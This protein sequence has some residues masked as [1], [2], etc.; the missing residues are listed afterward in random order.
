MG[1]SLKILLSC[2]SYSELTGSE[3]Y[4]YELAKTLKKLGHGV[5]VISSRVGGLLTEKSEKIG[6]K[7]YDFSRPPGYVYCSAWG[8]VE[9]NGKMYGCKPNTF[10]KVDRVDF[11]II[12]TQ[13]TPITQTILK[14][15]PRIPKV[16]T[17]HSEVISLENPVLHDDIKKYIAIRPEIKE[18]LIKNFSINKKKIEVIYNPFDFERFNTKET[19][20]EGYL[21][22]VG[23]IDY[24][25]KSTLFDL[26]E[27]TKNKGMDFVIVGKDSAN[28]LD[29]LLQNDHVKHFDAVDNI[30]SYVKNCKETAGILL[31]RTSIEGWLCGKSG[32]IY[33][34]NNKGEI[35]SKTFNDPP[36]DLEKFDSINI[37][38]KIIDLYH[39]VI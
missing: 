24:L 28:Y 13:H 25:R 37:T 5:S 20:D 16:S 19:K 9:Y 39:Q 36:D 33:D 17:I 35:I 32:W 4:V 26:V 14:L 6:I 31:G 23:T 30:E 34:V 7:V 10:V 21:L 38:N 27:Y 22:F 1:K 3:V 8:D 29:E 18:H 12:H 15:Y 11:D 2:L